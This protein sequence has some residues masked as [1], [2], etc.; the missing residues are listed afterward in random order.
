MREEPLMPVGRHIIEKNLP[1]NEDIYAEN[2]KTARNKRC[3][4]V[5]SSLAPPSW[6]GR[7]FLVAVTPEVSPGNVFRMSFNI[8]YLFETV[9]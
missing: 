3:P 1:K 5:V 2:Y 4:R 7:P 6:A 8:R 9:N